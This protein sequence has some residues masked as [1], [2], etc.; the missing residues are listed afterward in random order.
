MHWN[1]IQWSLA[2][3]GAFFIG[4]SKTGI[5]GI[6]IFGITLFSSLMPARDS[7][8][9][10]LILLIC[11]DI[12]AVWSFHRHAVWSHLWRVFPCA[13]AGVVAGY[14]AMGHIDEAGMRK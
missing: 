11:A 5:A 7:V 6:G 2:C 14:F 4:L 10:V 8:G 13:A 1:W 9:L 12:V 3:L